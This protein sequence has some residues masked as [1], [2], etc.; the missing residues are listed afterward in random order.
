VTEANAVFSYD[1]VD[2]DVTNVYCSESALQTVMDSVILPNLRT[3]VGEKY[4]ADIEQTTGTAIGT[5]VSIATDMV[6]GLRA[7]VAKQISDYSGQDVLLSLFRQAPQLFPKYTQLSVPSTDTSFNASDAY[8]STEDD[9]NIPL[10]FKSGDIFYLAV[11]LRVS[12][13]AVVKIP[14]TVAVDSSNANLTINQDADNSFNQ[15]FTIKTTNITFGDIS[16]NPIKS[17]STAG[18]TMVDYQEYYVKITVTVA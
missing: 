6:E 9:I 5:R 14:E 15:I 4:E 11:K 12:P 1:W 16:N 8:A 10:D 7:A 2:N 18:L 17:D 13:S 3:W